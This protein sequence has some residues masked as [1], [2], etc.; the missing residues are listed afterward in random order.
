MVLSLG[1]LNVRLTDWHFRRI[2]LCIYLSSQSH[3][4]NCCKQPNADLVSVYFVAIFS[5]HYFNEFC[6]V[7]DREKT[8]LNIL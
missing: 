8:K 7:T 1:I 2:R 6:F 5:L 4:T 3:P